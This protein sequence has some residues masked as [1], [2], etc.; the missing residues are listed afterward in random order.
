[1]REARS[2]TGG[3]ERRSGSGPQRSRS[4]RALLVSASVLLVCGGCGGGND[5]TKSID[6]GFIEIERDTQRFRQWKWS[7]CFPFY[8]GWI[9][10]PLFIGAGVFPFSSAISQRLGD[11]T[12]RFQGFDINPWF[13]DETTEIVLAIETKGKVY[14]QRITEAAK[15]HIGYGFRDSNDFVPFL[16]NDHLVFLT[17]LSGTQLVFI[18]VDLPIRSNAN[19]PVYSEGTREWNEVISYLETGERFRSLR[20]PLCESGR[21]SFRRAYELFESCPPR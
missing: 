5:S 4:H 15:G 8:G 12:A 6:S 20:L 11:F 10:D 9:S 3:I 7:G 14:E 1:V 19:T 18:L 2:E 16:M 21:K 13:R 17:T